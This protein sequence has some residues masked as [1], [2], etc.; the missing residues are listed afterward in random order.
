MTT[1]SSSW[2]R[3]VLFIKFFARLTVLFIFPDKA[4]P[5]V[6]QLLDTASAFDGTATP[7]LAQ[8]LRTPHF[9]T[10]RCTPFASPRATPRATPRTTPVRSLTPMSVATSEGDAAS[11][12]GGG[13]D[14]SREGSQARAAGK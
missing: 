12:A 2:V 7:Y 14:R 5:D 8:R 11:E 9:S 3:K 13:G 4:E 1:P 10:P 6:S